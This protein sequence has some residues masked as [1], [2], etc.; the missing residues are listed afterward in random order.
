MMT[1]RTRG[2]MLPL[3]IIVVLSMVGC[4]G[5]SAQQ[6]PTPVNTAVPETDGFGFGG[7]ITASGIVVPARSS[8]L[9]LLVTGMV[10]SVAV[11]AG[12]EVE[13]GD[14][15]LELDSTDVEQLIEQADLQA[16]Q[17]EVQVTQAEVSLETARA[18]LKNVS[19]WGPN[20]N[21]V[22]AAE[23][24]LNNAEAALQ[25][26]QGAYDQVAWMPGASGTPQSL[27][28]EQATNSYDMAKASLDY[29]YSARPD[30][31]R[32]A[33][34]VQLAEL[35]LEAAKLNVELTRVNL[36]IAR[37]SGDKM[38]LQAP[39][40]GTVTALEVSPGEVVMPGQLMLVLADLSTLRVETTD[41]SEIDVSRVTEGQAA[42]VEIEA[43]RTEVSGHVVSIGL[44]AGT[45]GGDVVYKVVVELDEKPEGL[46]W[47]MSAEVRFIE[48]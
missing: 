6:T 41:L 1:A 11:T 8:E 29:L 23:A 13:A 44:Q 30:V 43:L 2:V 31:G 33:A 14:L 3:L 42:T 32:A 10:K 24:A 38:S 39:F 40:D 12:E 34:Q 22:A 47:G 36:E 9:S 37:R 48:E 20:P 16:R 25:Q 7:G 45:V 46:R 4:G 15:L 21:Q 27:A 19:S 35:A 17:A 5:S 28:L 26:A 18:N